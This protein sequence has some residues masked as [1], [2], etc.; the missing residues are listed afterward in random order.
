[1]QNFQETFETA[2]RSSISAF[3][4]TVSLRFEF[5]DYSNGLA[6]FFFCS[7]PKDKHVSVLEVSEPYWRSEKSQ[8]SH[9]DQQAY[10]F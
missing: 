5:A 2:K 9:S 3:S 1:M 7:L 8:V 6:F 10:Y 4:V